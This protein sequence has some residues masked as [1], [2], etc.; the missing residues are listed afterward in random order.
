MMQNINGLYKVFKNQ[1]YK[2]PCEAVEQ[3][4][5][6]TEPELFQLWCFKIKPTVCNVLGF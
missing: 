5:N 3:C 2:T 4:L 1:S 6:K